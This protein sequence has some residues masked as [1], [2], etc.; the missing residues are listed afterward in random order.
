MEY[1]K[2]SATQLEVTKEIITPVKVETQ[3]YERKFIEDQIKAITESRDEMI[4][5]K[6]AELKECQDILDAM[7]AKGIVLKEVVDKEP[8]PIEKVI[9]K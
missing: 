9:V 8:L 6:E 7:N 1:T 4:A 2:I 3:T 5:L